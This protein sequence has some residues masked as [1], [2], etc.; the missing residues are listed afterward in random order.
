MDE[1]FHGN[2][3]GK[4]KDLV[5]RKKNK[6][7]PISRNSSQYCCWMGKL[8]GSSDISSFPVTL[9]IAE[10]A[11]VVVEAVVMVG[12]PVPVVVP[13]AAARWLVSWKLCET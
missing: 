12:V 3:P 2:Y 8:C 4:S 6:S 1:K 9:M 11:V 7:N 10:V 13:I 5:M